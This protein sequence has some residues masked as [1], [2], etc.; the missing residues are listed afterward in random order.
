MFRFSVV[1]CFGFCLVFFF[2]ASRRRHTRCALVTGV[3]TCALPIYAMGLVFF[4]P[5]LISTTT[6]FSLTL[7]MAAVYRRVIKMPP[8]WVWTVP[9][10]LV[11]LA[12]AAFPVIEVWAHA[13]FHQT[14]WRQAGVD[15]L[16]AILPDGRVLGAWTEIDF[17]VNFLSLLCPHN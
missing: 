6:G 11:A 7:L 14:G 15:F 9:I 8:M 3:Q 10:A 1:R 4:V 16:G 13:P 12:S 2:F 5:T 17:V